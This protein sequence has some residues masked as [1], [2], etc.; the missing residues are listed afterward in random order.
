MSTLRDQ[1]FMALVMIEYGNRL[2]DYRL[3]ERE[4]ALLTRNGFVVSQRHALEVL[5][6][7]P[8]VALSAYVTHRVL[9]ECTIASTTT[10]CLFTSRVSW[11]ETSLSCFASPFFLSGFRI[12]RLASLVR[13]DASSALVR[14]ALVHHWSTHRSWRSLCWRQA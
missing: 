2:F 7:F 4:L 10:I 1:G 3:N 14:I 8:A 6:A 13:Q 11:G 12:A 5:Y 9:L